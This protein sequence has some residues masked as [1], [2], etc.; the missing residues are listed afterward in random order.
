M[1]V[2]FLGIGL[3]ILSIVFF[4]YYPIHLA[5][6]RRR[7]TTAR[8]TI[9]K[10]YKRRIER[11]N[12]T[13]IDYQYK[14]EFNPG[15]GNITIQSPHTSLSKPE[16]DEVTVEYNPDKPKDAHI[17]EFHGSAGTSKNILYAALIILAVGI[18][19]IG[20]SWYVIL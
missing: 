16:G 6:T 18:I 17:V 13:D 20:I 1:T 15:D 2:L 10:V 8:G 3:I 7:K 9:V 5:Q 4:I 12:Y 11:E 19:C 14:V